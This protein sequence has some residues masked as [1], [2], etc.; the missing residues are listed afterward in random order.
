[1]LG[2]VPGY[3]SY[4]NGDIAEMMLFNRPLSV[5][6][7]LTVNEYLNSKYGLVPAIAAAPTNLVADA[8]STSQISLTWDEVLNGGSTQMSLERST[9]SNGMFTVIAQVADAQSYVDTNLSAGTTYY[10]QVRA[11]NAGQWSGYSDVAPATTLTVGT[12]L[13]FG[14]LAMWLK[15]DAG[16]AEIGTNTPV[17]LW[18]DQSGNGNNAI[19]LA[20]GNQPVWTANAMGDRPVVHFDGTARYFY[21]PPGSGMVTT[22]AEVVIVLRSTSS[23]GY[24]W[25]M[26][27]NGGSTGYPWGGQISEGFGSMNMYDIGMPAQPLTQFNVYEVSAETGN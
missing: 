5:G 18:A 2:A 6:E 24:L 7:R 11:E 27:G 14:S 9:A 19:Q 16:A 3:G 21:L 13:P 25:S 26:N 22:G 23:G 17:E 4:F 1:M 12:D 8:V 10:Y 15:A 20:S